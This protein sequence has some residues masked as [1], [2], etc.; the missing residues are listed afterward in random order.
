MLESETMPCAPVL[1]TA[2]KRP[3]ET[4]LV[5]EQIRKMRP[6]ILFVAM[7]GARNGNA[8]E[9]ELV[10]EVRELI[11]GKIDWPVDLK[12]NFAQTNMGLRKRMSSAISW[13]FEE[14]DGLIILED[15][16]IP[17]LD[18]FKFCTELL[19]FYATEPRVGAITGDNFQA[20][21]F[22][23][24][25]SY[26]FSRFPHCWGWATWRRAWQFYDDAMSDWPRKRET[27]W[28][29]DLFTDPLESIYWQNFFEDVFAEKIDSWAY[30][31]TYSLWKNG[32]LTATP[33]KNLVSNI[34]VGSSATNTSKQ[35]D[36]L[37]FVQTN[38]IDFPLVHPLE[39]TREIIADD[40]VQRNHFGKAKDTSAFGCLKRLFSRVIKSLRKL[41]LKKISSLGAACQ[42]ILWPC[43][44]NSIFYLTK[45]TYIFLHYSQ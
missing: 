45:M 27:R 1:L 29:F 25:T 3:K 39:L 18:F 35:I 14:V 28:L 10:Q 13:A 15:D 31:W 37:H 30:R 40:F 42:H 23:C 19:D 6:R 17:E 2:F 12:T 11:L 22:N 34:G 26:Y 32:L 21:G 20:K 41:G 8:G 9:T 5:F 33:Q 24:P 43:V 38:S 4:N 36:H 44:Y 7:D 16:C